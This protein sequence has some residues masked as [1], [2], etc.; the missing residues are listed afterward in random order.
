MRFLLF[1]FISVSFFGFYSCKKSTITPYQPPIVNPDTLTTGWTKNTQVFSES[2]II[3]AGDIYFINQNVG[4]ASTNISSI[5]K[6]MDGGNTWLSLANGFSMFNVAVTPNDRSFFMRDNF[7]S[8]TR[9]TD[10]GL[11]F[12]NS[13]AFG[14]NV[15]DIYFSD[16]VT[17]ICTTEQ[18]ILTTTNGGDTWNNICIIPNVESL[19]N[20]KSAV[21]MKG[22]SAWIGYGKYIY[23]S[24]D[25]LTTWRLD[26]LPNVISNIGICGISAPSTSVVYASSFTGYLFKSTNG[27]NTF[28]FI[29]KLDLNYNA[30]IYSDLHFVSDTLGFM[31]LG[32]RIYKTEDG[33]NTW[34]VVVALGIT[35][36]IEIHFT[37]AQHGWAICNDGSILK[38]N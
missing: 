33:G 10:G 8:I 19:T 15:S 26:S 18:N 35:D 25:N 32:S 17:G 16:N 31:S 24:N 7:D 13:Y 37:D 3:H 4:Y 12:S 20:K 9:S 6:T 27:G 11:N 36:L 23:H 38:Y 14:S 30:D 5:Y 29:K 2:G 22:N 21:I 28:N 1:L 34:N